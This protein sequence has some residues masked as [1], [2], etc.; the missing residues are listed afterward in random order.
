MMISNGDQV[1]KIKKGFISPLKC[2]TN[3]KTNNEK[4]D[5]LRCENNFDLSHYSGN[6]V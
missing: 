1:S 5:L 2:L 3:Y 6:S 4:Y